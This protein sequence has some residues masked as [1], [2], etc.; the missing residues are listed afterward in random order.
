[1]TLSFVDVRSKANNTNPDF[2][3]SNKNPNNN[4]HEAQHLCKK[5]QAGPTPIPS[6]NSLY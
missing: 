4:S 5:D 2:T 3:G 6:T 1:M